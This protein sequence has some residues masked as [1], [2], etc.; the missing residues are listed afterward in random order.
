MPALPSHGQREVYNG[1]VGGRA[2][3][4]ISAMKIQTK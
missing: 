2:E 1:Q 3:A 4:S